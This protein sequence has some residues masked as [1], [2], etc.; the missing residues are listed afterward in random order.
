MATK[1][2]NSALSSIFQT[3]STARKCDCILTVDGLEVANFEAK[4]ETASNV[5]KALQFRKNIKI[6]KSILLELESYNI[7]CPPILDIHGTGA[8]DSYQRCLSKLGY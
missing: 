5:D 2:S 1:L 3:S 7:E 6:N 4:K 8:C